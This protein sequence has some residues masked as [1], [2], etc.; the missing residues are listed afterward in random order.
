M[1]D[2][3][4]TAIIF[5]VLS[6][7]FFLLLFYIGDFS[8]Q[9]SILLAILLAIL[10]VYVEY[11]SHG[12]K[13]R[14]CPYYLDIAPNWFLILSDFRL[15]A[16]PE[17]WS[18]IEEYVEHA[19]KGAYCLLRDNIRIT[20]LHPED[21]TSRSMVYT[22]TVPH[23]G[24]F[25]T[26]VHFSEEIN[27]LSFA[28]DIPLLDV[29]GKQTPNFLVNSGPDGFRLAISIPDKF[30]SE[31]QN[32]CPKPDAINHQ[33]ATGTVELTL[34][35][36]PNSEFDLYWKPR[37]SQVSYN[38]KILPKLQAYIREQRKRFGWEAKKHEEIPEL[39][40]NWPEVI[41]HK[42]FEVRHNE[43]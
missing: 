21:L 17:Y 1:R 40:I 25:T 12:S 38:M 20:V 10:A 2:R 28:S 29:F 39:A 4:I 3:A 8:T 31:I 15:L 11:L 26:K 16:K 30:W 33:H 23:Q 32:S 22:S 7:C 36:I 6:G 13:A 24:Y 9:Q 37:S 5:V 35:V 27:P 42:Y 14:F 18:K 19:P 34:A 43:I 41:N